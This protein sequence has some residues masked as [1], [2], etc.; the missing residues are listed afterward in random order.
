MKMITKENTERVAELLETDAKGMEPVLSH[1]D[2]LVVTNMREAA[3]ILR[4]VAAR[5]GG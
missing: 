4:Q 5:M 1:N 2:R 3:K